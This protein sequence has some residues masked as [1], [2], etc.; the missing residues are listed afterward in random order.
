MKPH[1]PIRLT[2]DFSHMQC[3]V[4][5]GE[6]EEKQ[7]GEQRGREESVY[8]TKDCSSGWTSMRSKCVCVCVCGNVCV[9][10]YLAA[11]EFHKCA[12]LLELIPTTSCL[13]K[14]QQFV[15]VWHHLSF[16]DTSAAGCDRRVV[17]RAEQR[18]RCRAAQ[19]YTLGCEA[20]CQTCLQHKLQNVWEVKALASSQRTDFQTNTCT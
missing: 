7:G 18:R 5:W 1:T 2:V 20:D 14:G 13:Y 9:Y 16:A 3:Q 4:G 19:T 15:R 11:W 6:R 12:T 10:F 17:S 8:M